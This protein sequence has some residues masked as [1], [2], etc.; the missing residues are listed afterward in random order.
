MLEKLAAQYYA[1]EEPSEALERRIEECRHKSAPFLSGEA[2]AILRATHSFH[3]W[4]LT[5]CSVDCSHGTKNCNITLSKGSTAYRILLSG[6]TS[7]SIDGE[8]A[9]DEANYPDSALNTSLAQVLDLWIDHQRR[10]EFCLLLDSE[11]FITI[12]ADTFSIRE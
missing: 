2:K 8:L 7:L 12:Q 11:R 4:Y 5:K 1:E 3:D 9:S 6:V 10:F